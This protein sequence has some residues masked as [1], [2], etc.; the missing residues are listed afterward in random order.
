M[1]TKAVIFDMDGVLIDSEICYLK[2]DLAFARTK[3]PDVTIDQ[4]YGMVGASKQDAWMVMERAVHN[5]QT[6]EE[7]RDDYRASVDVF[8]QVDYRAIFRSEAVEIL[9]LLKRRGYALALASSTQMELILRV[10]AENNITSYFD[11]IVS[12]SQFK[13]SKPNPEIY[14]YTAKRLGVEPTE[15]LVIEDSTLGI[16]AASRAGMTIAALIDD[17]FG[18]DRSLADYEIQHL[19]EIAGLLGISENS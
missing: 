8:S 17:R 19:G 7:L 2:F 11:V 18:F 16:T 1:T 14:F 15:C 3:N 10:L 13:Q 4:L 6:W 5:G 12:G 9:D